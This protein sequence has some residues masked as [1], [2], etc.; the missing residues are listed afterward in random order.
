MTT[1]QA[2]QQLRRHLDDSQ[3]A[4]A[5]R[6][7]LSIRAIANYESDR[8]PTGRVLARLETLAVQQGRDDLAAVFRDAINKE[9]G[10]RVPLG[11]QPETATEDILVTA[12]LTVLRDQRYADLRPKLRQLLREVARANLKQWEQSIGVSS[13]ARERFANAFKKRGKGK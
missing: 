9:L 3:Q 2:T 11:N 8:T 10:P 1:R 7:G 6:L 13:E 4:F 12:V 5:N